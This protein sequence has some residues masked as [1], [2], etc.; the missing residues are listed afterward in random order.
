[1]SEYTTVKISKVLNRKLLIYKYER[2]LAS[3]EGVIRDLMKCEGGDDTNDEDCD[4]TDDGTDVIVD[5]IV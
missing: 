2:G 3:V 1:M 5:E 4:N